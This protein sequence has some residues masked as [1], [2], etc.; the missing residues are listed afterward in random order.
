[1]LVVIFVIFAVAQGIG[2]TS[3]PSGDAAIVKGGPSGTDSVSEAEVKRATAQQIAAAASE[4]KEKAP[5]PGSKKFEERQQAA[6][7][8]L[9]DQIWI[10]GQAEEMNISVTPKQ[11]EESL[12]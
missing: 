10:K 11:I 2:A 1:M 6:F 4:T 12:A 7:S 3:V 8:E 5:K 9:L